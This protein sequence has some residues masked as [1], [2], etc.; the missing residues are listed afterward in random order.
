MKYFENFFQKELAEYNP[1]IHP[2]VLFSA[3]YVTIYAVL[4]IIAVL[5]YMFVI[6]KNEEASDL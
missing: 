3:E 5:V 6:K 4:T 1:L 2:T